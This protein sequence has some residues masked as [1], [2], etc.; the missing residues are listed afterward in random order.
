MHPFN[1]NTLTTW[2]NESNLY[3]EIVVDATN[4]L[5]AENTWKENYPFVNKIEDIHFSMYRLDV[6]QDYSGNKVGFEDKPFEFLAVTLFIK[7]DDKIIG[8]YKQL[9]FF[10]GEAIDDFILTEDPY[11]PQ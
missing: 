9:L 1:F 8:Y 2:F 11:Y 7:H 5:M 3:N 6:I 4:Y 10:N